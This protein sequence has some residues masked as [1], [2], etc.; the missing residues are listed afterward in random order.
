MECASFSKAIVNGDASVHSPVNENG[1]L[2]GDRA[3]THISN[4]DISRDFSTVGSEW[5]RADLEFLNLEELAFQ[6][7]KVFTL[8]R[9]GRGG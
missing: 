5:T 6:P 3:A 9:E 1:A 8:L 4:N 2:V 7:F